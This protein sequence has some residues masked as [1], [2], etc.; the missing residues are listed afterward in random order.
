MPNFVIIIYCSSARLL[1]L[2]D[3]IFIKLYITCPAPLQP[4]ADFIGYVAKDP[5]HG[6][7]ALH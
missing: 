7:G 4:T 5:M 1:N 2:L 6:R 3:M